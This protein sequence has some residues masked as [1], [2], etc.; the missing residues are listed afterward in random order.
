[1][2]TSGDSTATFS[3]GCTWRLA[4][5]PDSG[6]VA[7]ASFSAF[8]ASWTCASID[9]TLP[10]ATLNEDSALSNAFCEMNLSFSRRVFIVRVFSASA[11]CA[12]ALSSAP[13]RSINFES[14]SVVSMRTSSWPAFT[15]SPSRTVTSRTSPGTLAL[16]I[17]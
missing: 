17:A 9:F 4:T 2:V 3:P 6:A 8:R 16:T 1:M 14:R 13:T 11:S 10:W 15:V 12:L 5:M 7:M